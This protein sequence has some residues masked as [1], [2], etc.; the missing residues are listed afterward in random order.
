VPKK[1]QVRV[2]QLHVLHSGSPASRLDFAR[3]YTTGVTR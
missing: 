2:L 1:V 3:L